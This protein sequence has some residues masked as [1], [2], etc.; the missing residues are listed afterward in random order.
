[1]S[2][3][4]IA[5]YLRLSMDDNISDSLSISNQR[6]L[7]DG[8]I[9]DMEIPNATV[10]EFIDNGYSGTNMERP[11]LQEMLELA[12]CNGLNCIL[13]KDFSRFSRNV[14]E[15]GYYIE[16][17]FP[18]Y[19]IRF[20][21]VSDG[22][23]SNDYKGDT[24]GIDVAFKFLL[25]EYYS[26]D[27][28]KK[29]RSAKHTKMRS[30]EHIVADATYGY[31]KNDA[32]TWEPDED[33]A[34]VVREIYK[35]ALDGLSKIEI[36]KRLFEA[37]HPTPGE[38]V[39]LRR[40]KDIIPKCL[41]RTGRVRHILTNPQYIGTYVAGR[42]FCDIVGS[43]R[44]I[45]RDKSEWIMIPDRHPPIISK[46][47]F[48]S[49]QKVVNAKTK[50]EFVKQL[51]GND[52]DN[53]NPKLPEVKIVIPSIPLYGF[54][55]GITGD[56]EQDPSAANIIKEIFDMALN[57]VSNVAI[58]DKLTASGY[59]TPR[60]HIKLSKGHDI[61]P[62]CC[63]TIDVV[64]R[65]LNKVEYAGAY[66]SGKYKKDPNTGK[67]RKVPKEKWNIMPDVYP[68]I[69][70][71]ETYERVHVISPNRKNL[72]RGDYLLRGKVTCG[73]CGHTM[74]RERKSNFVYSCRYTMPNSAASCHRMKISTVELDA[75]VLC[76]IK[77][78]AESILNLENLSDLRRAEPNVQH[79]AECEY[80]VKQLIG[81]R[82][83]LYEKFIM[84]EI[85][86]EAYEAQRTDYNAQLDRLNARISLHKLA[87]Q[88]KEAGQK[89]NALAKTALDET[90]SRQ[91]L[92]NMLV[93][94]V[95]V[96]PNNH[97][98]IKWKVSG[99]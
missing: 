16:Q 86:K 39:E 40:G 6:L 15:S 22:F 7:L 72:Q 3:Y 19:R 59:P 31:R 49:V 61:T 87:E 48:E 13:V 56:L 9:E 68:A 63:W 1:M 21:S 83:A 53:P 2:G 28:S 76:T 94:K 51:W 24:G 47:I 55:K 4:V 96:L 32:G 89:I 12:R 99:F 62:Q 50:A 79:L 38:Y 42:Q 29:I 17:V 70:T 88:K 5:K 44:S 35:M 92:V 85:D 95:Y 14:L 57:G 33:T 66:A 82:Q 84:R 98:E 69:V 10:L 45:H 52:T 27:L 73:C 34:A 93:D 11:A 54:R 81:Q 64:Y 25:H 74:V 43:R 36:C 90:T 37:G 30:G 23:D 71:K 8:Y 58:C 60:E 77:K 46:D 18:L 75:I 41:W 97:V 80:Q 78:Q 65:I 67:H 20:I 26:I 91:E